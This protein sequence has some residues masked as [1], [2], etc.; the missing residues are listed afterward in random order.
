MVLASKSLG[1]GRGTVDSSNE[2]TIDCC[3]DSGRV[4][5]AMRRSLVKSWWY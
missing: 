5:V 2:G 1:N 4:K 3:V